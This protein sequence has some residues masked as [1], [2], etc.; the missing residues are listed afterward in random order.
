M[1]A[2]AYV[3]AGMLLMFLIFAAVFGWIPIIYNYII[4]VATF[5]TN[6]YNG[7]TAV[8]KYLAP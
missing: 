4:G 2:I 7:L 6:I 1:G 5:L 8:G 3:F